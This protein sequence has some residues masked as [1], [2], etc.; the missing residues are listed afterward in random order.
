MV[1]DVEPLEDP[2]ACLK[3]DLARE[4]A[5]GHTGA[6]LYLLPVTQFWARFP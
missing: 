2:E 4:V 3:G 6:E 1:V 5:S